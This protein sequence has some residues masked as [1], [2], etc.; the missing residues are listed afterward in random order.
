MKARA[1][2][3][4]TVEIWVIGDNWNEHTDIGSLHREA[5]EMAVKQIK[6]I[7]E[8]SRQ[9]TLIGVPKVEAIF[10]EDMKHG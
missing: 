7:C 5:K 9:V 1:R 4:T 2:V 3:T 8:R 6:D 10:T